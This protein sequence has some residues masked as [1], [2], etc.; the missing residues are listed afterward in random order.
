MSIFG[1]LK[2]E[3]DDR[4]MP[5]SGAAR[6]FALIG[7]HFWKFVTLNLLFLLFSLPIVTLPAALSALNRVC[8]LLVRR[9]N[10]FLWSDFWEEF[11]RSLWRSMPLGLLYGAELFAGYYLLSLGISNAQS[12]YGMLFAALGAALS[13]L[14]LLEGAWVFVLTALLPLGNRDTL[15][16][17][18]ALTA[19]EIRRDLGIVGVFAL[20]LLFSLLLFPYSLFAVALIL[21]SLG[22][23]AVCF[24]VNTP[25]QTRIIAPFEA[26]EGAGDITA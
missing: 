22:Q 21:I 15:R 20:E 9:G 3:G 25:V 16:N 1:Y 13:V 10:C 6:F 7:T 11:R 4:P 8:V 2:K 12:F 19:L 23:F 17:A 18:R 26:G 5:E 24:L 14:A